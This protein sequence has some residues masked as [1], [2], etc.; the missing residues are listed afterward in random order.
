[1]LNI[2]YWGKLTLP[3]LVGKVIEAVA[4][5]SRPQ[6]PKGVRKKGALTIFFSREFSEISKSTFLHR[7]P[8]VDASEVNFSERKFEEM[9]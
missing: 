6:S 4:Q 8:L 5:S 9:H 7:T 3:K 1:M 2:Y